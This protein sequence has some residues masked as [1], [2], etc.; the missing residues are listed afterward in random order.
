MLTEMRRSPRSSGFSTSPPFSAAAIVVL[1]IVA[2][3]LIVIALLLAFTTTERFQTGAQSAL[4]RDVLRQVAIYPG[5]RP[6]FSGENSADR[7]D[8]VIVFDVWAARTNAD[9]V[10]VHFE[11]QFNSRGWLVHPQTGSVYPAETT[12]LDLLEP[13]SSSI[14]GVA[15]PPGVQAARSPDVTLY[16]LIVTGWDGRACPQ[17]N[18]SALGVSRP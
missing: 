1:A 15:I 7:C 18:R 4:L 17:L 9:E 12:R 3:A 8:T 10:R 14:A 6:L 16:A 5:G 11:Q 2:L 13:V